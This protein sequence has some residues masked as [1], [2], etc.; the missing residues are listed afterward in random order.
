M[1][2]TVL[3]IESTQKQ[4]LRVGRMI[5][6]AVGGAMINAEWYKTEGAWSDASADGDAASKGAR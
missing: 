1:V 5:D 4:M 2:A 6:R 3:Q